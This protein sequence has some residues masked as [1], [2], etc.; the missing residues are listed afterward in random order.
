MDAEGMFGFAKLFGV[1]EA[2][3][4]RAWGGAGSLELCMIQNFCRTLSREVIQSINLF[5]KHQPLSLGRR[6]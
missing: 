1:A 2:W 3:T 6:H 4:S 5:L